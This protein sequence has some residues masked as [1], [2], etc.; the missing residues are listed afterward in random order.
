MTPSVTGTRTGTPSITATPSPAPLVITRIDVSTFTRSGGLVGLIGLAS[1]GYRSGANTLVADPPITLTALTLVNTTYITAELAVLGAYRATPT[2]TP[3]NPG[4]APSGRKPP[5]PPPGGIVYTPTYLL[6]GDRLRINASLIGTAAPASVALRTVTASGASAVCGGVRFV[7]PDAVECTPLLL[8]DATLATPLEVVFTFPGGAPPVAGADVGATTTLVIPRPTLT[9]PAA[10]GAAAPSAPFPV[11]LSRRP[12][13]SVAWPAAGLPVARGWNG[14]RVFTV[15]V[16]TQQADVAPHTPPSPAML[17]C[18]ASPLTAAAPA[19][20]GV[21]TSAR[22]GHVLTVRAG[23]PD[24]MVTY[25]PPRLIALHPAT[26]VVTPSSAS[27]APLALHFVVRGA[28]FG[29]AGAPRIRA[30][31]VGGVLCGVIA[32]LNDTTATCTNWTA[33]PYANLSAIATHSGNTSSLPLSTRLAWAP[34]PPSATP[35]AFI[36]AQRLLTA[37]LQPD[38]LAVVPRMVQAGRPVSV[39][40]ANLSLADL[41]APGP[42]PAGTAAGTVGGAPCAG[43][44][45]EAAAMV[46]CTAPTAPVLAPGYPTVAIALTGGAGANAR[47][48]AAAAVTYTTAFTL[49]WNASVA[50]GW[51]AA[52]LPGGRTATARLPW[53][54]PPAVEVAGLG[55]GSCWLEVGN[56]TLP[57]P[58]S[59][60]GRGLG[61]PLAADGSAPVALVGSLVSPVTLSAE[62]LLAVLPFPDAGLSAPGG[63]TALLNAQCLDANGATSRPPSQLHL[64][65]ATL[66]ASWHPRSV[67]ALAGAGVVHPPAALPPATVVVSW[68]GLAAPVPTAYASLLTCQA[69]VLAPASPI[70]PPSTPLIQLAA[71]LQLSGGLAAG[72][73]NAT[74]CDAAGAAAVGATGSNATCWAITLAGASCAAV[75]A[76]GGATLDIVAECTWEP[77]GERVRLPVLRLLVAGGGTTWSAATAAAQ[78][79]AAGELPLFLEQETFWPAAV[80]HNAT[81]GLGARSTAWCALQATGQSDGRAFLVVS[82][83][84]TRLAVA[85]EAS[86][87][88]PLAQPVSLAVRGTAGGWLEVQLVCTLWDVLVVSSPVV[89]LRTRTL[90]IM[91]VGSLPTSFVASDGVVATVLHPAPAF[92]VLASPDG[93]PVTDTVCTLSTVT[94]GTEVRFVS[95]SG[96][97]SATRSM[98]PDGNGS[99]AVGGVL[100]VAPN[101]EPSVTLSLACS[102]TA[103][104]APL[105]YTWALR[106][107]VLNMVVCDAP[108]PETAPSGALPPWSV[109]LVMANATSGGTGVGGGGEGA[110]VAAACNPSLVSGGVAGDAAA[111]AAA[112][113]VRCTAA[114]VT[115]RGAAST[116]FVNGGTAAVDAD[117]AG[118]LLFSAL[119]LVGTRG[120]E[121]NLSVGCTLGNLQ[122]PG[123]QVWPVRV[124]PCEAG[125]A[126][127][128]LVCT[129]CATGSYT[130]GHNEPACIDCPPAGVTCNGGIL[131]LLPAFFRPASENG[132]KV[133]P[134][135]LLLPCFNTEACAVNV[136]DATYSCTTGYTGALCGTCEEGYGMFSAACRTCWNPDA[137]RALLAVILLIFLAALVV[138]ALRTTTGSADNPAPIALKLLLGYVQ[139]VSSMRVFKAAGTRAFR[140]AM[141]WTDSVSESPLSTGPIQCQLQWPFLVRYAVTVA[142]PLIAAAGALAIFSTVSAMRAM[143]WSPRPRLDVPAWRAAVR[144]WL[145]QRRPVSIL[146]FVLFVAYMPIVSASFRVLQ[147]MTD[148]IDGVYWLVSDLSVQCYAGQHAVATTLAVVVLAV[149]GAGFPLGIYRI[150]AHATARHLREPHFSNAF[151]FLYAG[152]KQGDLGDA[153]SPAAEVAASDAAGPDKDATTAVGGDES[154]ILSQS[155]PLFRHANAAGEAPR[156][157]A[158]AAAPP[159][160]AGPDKAPRAANTKARCCRMTRKAA[161]LRGLHRRRT[162]CEW[163]TWWAPRHTSFV[164]WESVVI[165]RKAIVV[166]LSAA[167]PNPFNQV[168]GAVLLFSASVA[169]QL[170]FQPFSRKLF[171]YLELALL[172]S[173]YLT[174]AISTILLPSA[175]GTATVSEGTTNAVTVVLILLNVAT[176]IA[177][178]VVAVRVGV[179]RGIEVLRDLLRRCR[180]RPAV[181][182]G[183]SDAGSGTVPPASVAVAVPTSAAS[184]RVLVLA[185]SEESPVAA[186]AAAKTLPPTPVGASWRAVQRSGSPPDAPTSG[187]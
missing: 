6:Y 104:D 69:V 42:W 39:L 117:G 159:V 119:K 182:A 76:P 26:I 34:P 170:H 146:L 86:G 176:V 157:T 96:V 79:A 9:L 16:S 32:V 110:L 145:D 45:V 13:P 121:Y 173:L 135:S 46:S 3:T 83:A 154:A 22:L 152:Y 17:S 160:T 123:S 187:L 28:G 54:P 97:V 165:S 178:G 29:T 107:V 14:T 48:L 4:F 40:A 56:V 132:Q 147:C 120:A 168:V 90:S 158:V 98:V 75:A 24:A 23:A 55:S 133:G 10:I 50:G 1:H 51:A 169:L 62:S 125:F 2:P 112:A 108:A 73:N 150:M 127:A 136:T 41:C 61:L 142:L 60:P 138:V 141:G 7:P 113:L 153:E 115:Q 162:I 166:L 89:R 35:P 64:T 74:A 109:S 47:P 105:P 144:A 183:V 92:S 148:A 63:T 180:G 116:G 177:L 20:V 106:Q 71:A 88:G 19:V 167:V 163:L 103:E 186:S 37:V 156:S 31:E 171:N 21:G 94:P 11:L 8:P 36:A 184:K 179:G 164:W 95:D 128:G 137:S 57:P 99:V 72:S 101:T 18:A 151:S 58:T 78:G 130:T 155:N 93:T 52:I 25:A 82:G 174:A 65:T 38:M 68:A 81:P 111:A 124:K 66:S 44:V 185:A 84:Q 175:M 30:V 114:V 59:S 15:P 43:V 100:V 126:P 122:L 172:V 70:P 143:H 149:F 53:S 80:Y 85:D 87:T 77:T 134:D 129:P 102:R 140:D 67:A 91:S 12:P 131:R 139:A 49:S 5:L 161:P 181:A 33:P 118:P 27:P